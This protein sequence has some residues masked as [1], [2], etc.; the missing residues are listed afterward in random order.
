MSMLILKVLAEEV[1]I[2]KPDPALPAHMIGVFVHT[3][4]VWDQTVSEPSTLRTTVLMHGRGTWG[5][6]LQTAWPRAFLCTTRG[7]QP[8]DPYECAAR[9][10]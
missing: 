2:V 4:K 3:L 9:P 10:T 8:S 6:R 1:H 5:L 7:G